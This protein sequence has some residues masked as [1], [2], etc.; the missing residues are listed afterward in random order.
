MKSTTQITQVESRGSIK[1]PRLM[2]V[3]A[4]AFGVYTGQSLAGPTDSA[5]YDRN[6]LFSPSEAVLLAE[7]NGRV[8]IYDG[9]EHRT[10]DRALDTQFERIDSM[11]FVRTRET[12]PDGSVEVD[13]DCD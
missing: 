7:A 13:D 9:L 4:V 5:S 10:V 8:T 12:S 2:V 1:K 3:L 11:M 6:V